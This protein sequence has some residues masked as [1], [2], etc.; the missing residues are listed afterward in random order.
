MIE[1]P[2]HIQGNSLDLVLTNDPEL[3]SDLSIHPHLSHT[4]TSDHFIISFT[5]TP[6]S[7]PSLRN[8]PI[9]VFDYPKADLLGLCDY[10]LSSDLSFCSSSNDIELVWSTLKNLIYLSVD[11][12]IP[13]VRL[14]SHQRPKWITPTLQHDVNC[15][16]TLKKKY[17]FHSTQHNLTKL[18]SAEYLLED[19]LKLTKS[20]YENNLAH[21]LATYESNKIY[22]YINSLSSKH[23]FPHSMHF[24]SLSSI[25]DS[26]KA[27]L[28]NNYFYSIFTRSSFVLP[29]TDELPSVDSLISDVSVSDSDVYSELTKLDTSKAM[30]TDNIGP[31]ILKFCA[32]ALYLPIHH[33][34]S[35]SLSHHC[36]QCLPAE[37][38]I[39]SIV[40]V[41]K[42]GDRTSI[43]NYRPI[44]LLCTISLVLERLIYNKMSQPLPQVEFHSFNLA[45]PKIALMFT[46][47][48]YLSITFFPP[49]VRKPRQMSYTLTS[50]KLL[51]VFL[52]MS[53]Y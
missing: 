24:D 20:S 23:S 46:S 2:T 52:T 18:L 36:H 15:F 6:F 47:Y 33:L 53:F 3:I 12:F 40:P 44:S 25:T 21:K 34:F 31:N 43:I 51:I 17:K 14:R 9:Y 32:P 49:L 4:L 22:K 48:F 50:E 10:L 19:N 29:T 5:V 11:L 8:E 41:F 13:K 28:F 1:S 26:A 16:R 35:L 27:S 45:S 38:C 30:G 37:W 7:L 42:S 39:H